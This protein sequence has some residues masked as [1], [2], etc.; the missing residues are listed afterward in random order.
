MTHASVS[1]DRAAG[2]YDETR[3]TDAESLGTILDMLERVV[4]GRGPVLELGVGT[5]QLAL[6]LSARGVPVVGIDLSAEMM[7][8]LREKGTSDGLPL[9]RGDVTRLP[10]AEASLG[11]AYARWVLH[12]VPDWLQALRELDRTL[13]AGGRIA[14]EPGGFSGPFREM[15]LRFKEI[16]GDAVVAVGL[17]AI[18]RDRQL[19]DGFASI[20]WTL[21]RTVPIV[22]EHS[23]SLQEIFD[24]IPTKRWSWTWRVPEVDL[25]A[26][27]VQVRAWARDRFGDLDRKI[28]AEATTWR[29][30]ERARAPQ[31]G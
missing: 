24:E 8:V 6:P 20:G 12:L 7:R 31:R 29:I 23:A 4:H 11:G 10:F 30:Y 18:D 27:T 15:Y 14:I 28:P 21:E 5:G 2:Y 26:A 3:V 13:V 25:A 17:T 9:V 16:L 22:Y 19:D 1:F